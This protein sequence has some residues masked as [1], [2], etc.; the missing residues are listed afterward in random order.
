MKKS[1][2]PR[3]TF[4]L[5]CC[6]MF[7]C[8]MGCRSRLLHCG[9]AEQQLFEAAYQPTRAEWLLTCLQAK[10]RVEKGSRGFNYS[11][12]FKGANERGDMIAVL[13]YVAPDSADARENM[14]VDILDCVLR[15]QRLLHEETQ[16]G[17]PFYSGMCLRVKVEGV[18]LNEELRAG[19]VISDEE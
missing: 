9:F 19:G 16:K 13:R 10:G 2:I 5:S 15:A 6:L 4:Y 18:G 17:I 14:L 8:A 7:V 3:Q 12:D 1:E 11:F